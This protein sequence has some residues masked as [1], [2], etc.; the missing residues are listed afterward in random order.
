M[1]RYSLDH[2]EFCTFSNY[3]QTKL[4]GTKAEIA[5]VITEFQLIIIIILINFQW[6]FS[7]YMIWKLV[8]SY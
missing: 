1:F 5:T 3:D 6:F 2:E 7:R 8:K 4:L